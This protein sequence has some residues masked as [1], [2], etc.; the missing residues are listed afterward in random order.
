M[1]ASADPFLL[2]CTNDRTVDNQAGRTVMAKRFIRSSDQT[3]DHHCASVLVVIMH[4]FPTLACVAQPT[5]GL[6][7]RATRHA[8][9]RLGSVHPFVGTVSPSSP[10]RRPAP[11]L[12]QSR[13][14]TDLSEPNRRMFTS[15][16]KDGELEQV[17][18]TRRRPRR[19]PALRQG[20][21]RFNPLIRR[22]TSLA[23]RDS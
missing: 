11:Y 3:E 8:A 21:Q 5:R 9:I 6:S 1:S 10:T 12:R 15:T 14:G 19:V 22:C 4:G 2:E 17:A 16:L 18:S 20:L 13:S 23:D 7:S